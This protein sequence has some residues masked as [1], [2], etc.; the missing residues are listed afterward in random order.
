[1]YLCLTIKQIEG[2]FFGKKNYIKYKF[3]IS[4]NFKNVKQLQ[5][6]SNKNKST[7]KN[8]YFIKSFPIY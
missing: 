6:R 4:I 8:L 7:I 2:S 5:V 3:Y 1:M